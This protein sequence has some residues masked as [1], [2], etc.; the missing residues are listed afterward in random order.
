MALIHNLGFP[1]IGGK[2]ELKFALEGFWK[3]K[4]SESELLSKAKVVRPYHESP[5]DI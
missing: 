3:G 4:T 1:R 5:Q 2:P